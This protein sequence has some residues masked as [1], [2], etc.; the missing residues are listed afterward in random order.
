MAR[1]VAAFLSAILIGLVWSCSAVSSQSTEGKYGN[2]S[3]I[4]GFIVPH[5]HDDV[6]WLFTIEEYYVVRVQFIIGQAIDSL[7]MN[8]NRRFIIVEMAYFTIWWEK[9]ATAEQ[10]DRCRKLVANGQ[11]EFIIGGWTMEDEAC[12]TYSANIDQMTEGHQFLLNTFGVRPRFGW[13]VDPFG[14]SSVVHEHFALMGFDATVISRVDY[15]LKDAMTQN[16]SL[17]FV[18]RPSKNYG[19]DLEIFTHCMDYYSYSTSTGG[20][21][22]DDGDPLVN[23]TNIV[24]LSNA[25]VNNIKQRASWYATNAIL[26]PWGTDFEHFGALVDFYNMD[27]LIAHINAH[28]QEHGVVVQYATLGE[29][30]GAL[31][32]INHTW[33]TRD[34]TDWFPYADS[35]GSYWSGYF[36]SRPALKGYVRSRE[37]TLRAAETLHASVRVGAQFANYSDDIA[38]LEQLRQASGEATHHDAVAGTSNPWVVVMYADHLAAG[39]GAV[40]PTMTSNIAKL[41]TGTSGKSPSLTLDPSTMAQLAPGQPVAML[42]YN[43][44]SWNVTQPVR[45]P[46]F[47]SN[48]VVTDSLGRPVPSGV[49]ASLPTHPIPCLAAGTCGYPAVAAPMELFFEAQLPAMGYA[50]FFVSLNGSAC[51]ATVPAAVSPVPGSE[52]VLENGFLSLTFSQPNGQLVAIDNLVSGV[53][54]TVKQNFFRYHADANATSASEG[55][56]VFHPL[57]PA[58]LITAAP[59]S[60]EVRANSY[61]QEVRQVFTAPCLDP[62]TVDCGISQVVR[63]YTGS[64][65]SEAR[66]FI[67]VVHSVGPISPEVD[68]VTRYS[69]SLSTGQT[70]FTDNNCFEIQQ[71]TLDP[72]KS[73]PIAGNFFPVD[74]VA[75][76]RDETAESQFSVLVDRAQAGGSLSSG[77][78][79]LTMHRRAIEYDHKGPNCDDVDRL[80]N[81]RYLLHFDSVPNAAAQRTQLQYRHQFPPTVFFSSGAN[82]GAW[83]YRTQY[84]AMLQPFPDN[85]H[86]LTFEYLSANSSSLLVRLAHVYETGEQTPLSKPAAVTLADYLP[87]SAS[88]SVV[89]MTLSAVLP[90]SE[91]ARWS[92]STADGASTAANGFKCDGEECSTASIVLNPSQIRTFFVQP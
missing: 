10:Q 15:R 67:E 80:E 50:T 19:N 57:G 33:P 42:V 65:T 25:I 87:L 76:L 17:E 5:S 45:V 59:I 72:T 88:A 48:A 32:S 84:S 54:T 49:Q 30:F 81:V 62:N 9:T 8:P 79:E 41:A 63:I 34:N 28:S 35:P 39:T 23:E 37:N 47:C 90:T 68:I 46:A 85:V 43:A 77:Q 2:S 24:T 69:T 21:E 20:L 91:L 70:L 66:N 16:R 78:V 4:Y 14:A 53:S 11:L 44:L 31:H 13:Q 51:N 12:T 26:F 83:P 7:W 22:W 18:W 1:S 73:D 92:W 56:Y 55:T 61:V 71:R 3:M 40:E 6:G 58:E 86:L 82:P 75:Y 74:C 52:F 38:A 60:F 29:F 89:E 36:T 64:N 27:Q